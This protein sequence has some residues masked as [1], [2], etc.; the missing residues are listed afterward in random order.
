[1]PKLL[2]ILC[3]LEDPLRHG[4]L[5]FQVAFREARVHWSLSNFQ[6]HVSDRFQALGNGLLLEPL[7]PLQH[8]CCYYL[9]TKVLV[10][11]IVSQIYHRRLI[12]H[13]SHLRFL[14]IKTHPIARSERLP[15]F[16]HVF[17][18]PKADTRKI[19]S[20]YLGFHSVAQLFACSVP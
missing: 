4:N 7:L 18:A 1:M 5:F 11:G 19:I 10:V 2:C 6:Q 17:F 16:L 15:Q 14:R 9:I 3:P 12:G 20:L 13:G 8:T